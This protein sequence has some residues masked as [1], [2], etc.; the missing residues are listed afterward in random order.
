MKIVVVGGSGLIGAKLVS[1][2]RQRGH[3]VVAAS[4][5]SGVNILTGEGLAGALADAR[6]VVDVANAPSFKGDAGLSFF[7]TSGRNLLDAESFAGVEH[8]VALSIV[9]IDRLLA[10]SYFR[11]KMAQENLVKASN[12]PYTILRSTQFFDFVR[13]IVQSATQGQTVRL[14]SALVHPV[15]SDDVAATLA[16]IAIAKPLNATI[17]LAGPEP[18]RL[19]EVARR[20]LRVNRDPR[21]V[22]TDD[23]ALYFGTELDDHSLTPGDNPRIGRSRFDDWLRHSIRQV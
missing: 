18:I 9:G 4:R 11:A 13:G 20:F 17:E 6:V 14:P 10:G 8:H 3:E 2:L 21:S 15:A 19:D 22:V 12:I 16:D 1:S 5:S 23:H 7:E